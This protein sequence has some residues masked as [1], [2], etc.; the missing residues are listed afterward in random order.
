MQGWEVGNI[1]LVLLDSSP[2]F[3]VYWGR[4]SPDPIRKQPEPAH[5]ACSTIMSSAYIGP[6]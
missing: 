5:L 6:Q 2:R 3:L 1:S 4:S